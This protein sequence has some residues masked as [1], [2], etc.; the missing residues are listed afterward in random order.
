VRIAGP[1]R[2]LIRFDLEVDRIQ[3]EFCWRRPVRLGL[4]MFAEWSFAIEHSQGGI[5][6]RTASAV[7]MKLI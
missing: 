7:G 5:G 1:I 3:V 6:F 2:S 4:P